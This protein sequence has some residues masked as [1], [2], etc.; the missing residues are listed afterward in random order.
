M[1]LE[2]PEPLDGK[3][4]K[5]FDDG[6]EKMNNKIEEIIN[7]TDESS[8]RYVNSLKVLEKLQLVTKKSL[9]D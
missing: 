9:I 7:E 8:E 3:Y 4:K 5:M 6:I 2:H 1:S